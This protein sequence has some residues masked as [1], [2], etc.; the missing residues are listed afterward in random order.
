MQPSV[1]TTESRHTGNDLPRL[2]GAARA[3]QN[4]VRAMQ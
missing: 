4:K 1:E 2:T 3:H